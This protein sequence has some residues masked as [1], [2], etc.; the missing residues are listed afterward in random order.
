[1]YCVTFKKLTDCNNHALVYHYDIMLPIHVL[2]PL[3]A[4]RDPERHRKIN[5]LRQL[6]KS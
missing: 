3:L 6:G 4:I 5:L 2:L 1:M